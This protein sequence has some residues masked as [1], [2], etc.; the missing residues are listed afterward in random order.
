M[1]FVRRWR[2]FIISNFS[3]V[4]IVELICDIGFIM[5]VCISL[6]SFCFFSIGF[7]FFMGKMF[8]LVVC[9]EWD[10][11]VVVQVLVKKRCI[12]FVCV[13]KFKIDD[14]VLMLLFFKFIDNGMKL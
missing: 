3:I 10:S 7:V 9:V 13:V 6:F 11:D 5:F 12:F 2:C 1:F 8:V 14:K 4:L